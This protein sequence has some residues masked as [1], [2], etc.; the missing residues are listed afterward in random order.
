MM[1]GDVTHPCN[2]AAEGAAMD[3]RHPEGEEGSGEGGTHDKS[4]SFC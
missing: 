2:K 4:P 1:Y 3:V